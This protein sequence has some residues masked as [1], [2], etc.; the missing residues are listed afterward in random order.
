MQ[1]FYTSG[2]RFVVFIT[3]AAFGISVFTGLIDPATRDSSI[4]SRATVK[5]NADD[6]RT[7]KLDVIHNLA[8]SGLNKIQ[9]ERKS[10]IRNACEMCRRNRTSMECNH[11][12]LDEDFPR[13]I[14][15]KNLLVDDKHK[16]PLKFSSCK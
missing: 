5:L 16:V 13:K 14:V 1:K 9:D 12:T 4:L 10:M 6:N 11:V 8:N 7:C 2:R 3:V 15:Y